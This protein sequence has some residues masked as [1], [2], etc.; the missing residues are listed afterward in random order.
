DFGKFRIGLSPDG[1]VDTTG[2][3]EI[4]CPRAKGHINTILADDVPALYM[5]QC[6]T[7]LLVSGRDWIDFV[8]FVAG[9]PL[10]VK[11]V[12]PDPLWFAAIE[13]AALHAAP[14]IADTVARYQAAPRHTPQTQRTPAPQERRAAR[15]PNRP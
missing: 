5:A 10:F 7:A 14:Q 8:S 11:R 12:T 6:Q 13:A 15:G 1:L 3:I 2:A 9:M 4:K